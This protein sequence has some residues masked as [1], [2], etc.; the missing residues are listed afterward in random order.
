[1]APLLGKWPLAELSE[2]GSMAQDTGLLGVQVHETHVSWVF[3]VG[4]RAFKIKKPVRTGFLD[5]TALA[6]RERV[7]AREVELNRRLAPD[8]Y[9]GVAYLIGHC[10]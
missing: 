1:L 6:Q 8:V 2:G 4:D 7:C 9:R 5:L 10:S 3:L